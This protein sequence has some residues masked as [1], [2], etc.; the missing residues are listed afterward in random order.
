[1]NEI[2]LVLQ[3]FPSIN[4]EDLLILAS[5]LLDYWD[6]KCPES[7]TS[8]RADVDK[9]CSVTVFPDYYLIAHRAIV[10]SEE[11]FNLWEAGKIKGG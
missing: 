2:D 9:R 4:R 1:M 10:E 6:N 3:K 8:L 5:I 7:L 11:F